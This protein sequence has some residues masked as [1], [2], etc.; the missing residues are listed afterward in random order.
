MQLN[1]W[2]VL[3]L[4]ALCLVIVAGFMRQ[5]HLYYMAAILLTLPG[6]SY[7]LGWYAQHDLDIHP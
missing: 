7:A 6:V 2:L 1:K 4:G 5:S 3:V